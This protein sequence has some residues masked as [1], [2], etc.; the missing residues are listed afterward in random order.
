[1]TPERLAEITAADAESVANPG[2]P[3]ACHRRELL[4][5]VQRLTDELDC[6]GSSSDRSWS[7]EVALTQENARL[8]DEVAELKRQVAAARGDLQWE[9]HH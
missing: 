1:M 8:T 5:E 7:R 3:S 4:A 9:R 6:A 2:C